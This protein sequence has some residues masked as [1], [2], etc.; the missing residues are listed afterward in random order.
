[1]LYFQTFSKRP[2]PEGYERPTRTLE[3]LEAI[4]SRYVPGH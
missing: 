1:V 3:E 4:Q 2:I